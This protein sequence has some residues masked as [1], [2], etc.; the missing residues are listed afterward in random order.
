[1]QSSFDLTGVLKDGHWVTEGTSPEESGLLRCGFRDLGITSEP[2]ESNVA[3]IRSAAARFVTEFRQDPLGFARIT[4]KLFAEGSTERILP[5]SACVR[6][7]QERY[8][9]E[10][11]PNDLTEVIFLEQQLSSLRSVKGPV[12]ILLDLDQIFSIY[13]HLQ[14]CKA[15]PEPADIMPTPSTGK[16]IVAVQNN[17]KLAVALP[18][19]AVWHVYDIEPVETD[20]ILESADGHIKDQVTTLGEIGQGRANSVFI[21]YIIHRVNF[22]DRLPRVS[23]DQLLWRFREK[24]K[25]PVYLV[26][27][28]ATKNPRPQRQT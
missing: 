23:H 11:D 18:P 17:P 13:P 25:G 27:G 3:R 6:L 8:D 19:R 26:Q 24:C 10:G 2:T 7:L 12:T 4:F 1:M 14:K 9:K 5:M 28:T 21:V 16:P 20:E 22:V 15:S